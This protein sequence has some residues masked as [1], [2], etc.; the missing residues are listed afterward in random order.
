MNS[1][2]LID[3]LEAQVG[4]IREMV[5]GVTREQAAWKP[6]PERWSVL[7]V[8]VHLLDEERE[9]FRVRLGLLLRDPKADWPPIDPQGWVT[10]REYAKRDLGETLQAF[11]K[12]RED[13][14]A[15]LNGLESPVWDNVKTHPVAG[16]LSAGD[17]LAS[18]VAHDLLHIR[19]LAKLHWDYVRSLAEPYSVAYAGDAGDW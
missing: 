7:E 17:M 11:L 15:W 13:S 5:Q 8:A 1:D 10:Q 14:L 19:Q 2:S 4:I 12:E 16:A 6:A 18:W 9:D 3:R